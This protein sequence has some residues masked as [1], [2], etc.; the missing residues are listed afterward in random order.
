MVVKSSWR[1]LDKNGT[2]MIDVSFPETLTDHFYDV[3][4][5]VTIVEDEEAIH[6]AVESLAEQ[7]ERQCQDAYVRGWNGWNRADLCPIPHLVEKMKKAF[8]EGDVVKVGVYL[9]M[10]H[11]RGVDNFESTERQARLT[12]LSE[13]ITK[14]V[15]AEDTIS[16][17]DGDHSAHARVLGDIRNNITKLDHERQKLLQLLG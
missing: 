3:S 15:A 4:L 7:I 13:E 14:L 8:V 11:G 12:W 16:R 9:T 10:L 5:P 6:I 17:L 2:K 1:N